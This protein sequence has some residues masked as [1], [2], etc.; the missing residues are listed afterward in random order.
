LNART[1]E[2][3]PPGIIVSARC[4]S[5]RDTSTFLLTVGGIKSP[6]G[7]RSWVASK[8]TGVIL[9][10]RAF[11]SEPRDFMQACANHLYLKST[12][13]YSSSTPVPN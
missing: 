12:D 8:Q 9:K 2:F 11:T 4:C 3:T 5:L 6:A 7:L 1:G 10:A 13:H